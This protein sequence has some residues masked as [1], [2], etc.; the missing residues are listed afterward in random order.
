MAGGDVWWEQE[1]PSRRNTSPQDSPCL[2][3]VPKGRRRRRIGTRGSSR[4]GD[5]LG[6]ATAGV[7]CRKDG[8]RSPRS[9]VLTTASATPMMIS[10][11]GPRQPKRK[12][13]KLFPAPGQTAANKAA[14]HSCA[15]PAQGARL[16]AS[17]Q[18]VCQQANLLP[19]GEGAEGGRKKA[20]RNSL[21]ASIPA[22]RTCSVR[23]LTRA[24]GGG[25]LN[26]RAPVSACSPTRSLIVF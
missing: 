14:R 25:G 19:T 6:T 11:P 9:P 1:Q 16:C 18:C 13:G 20:S 26:F 10:F 22:G 3:A 4:A 23:F 21:S 7:V 17:L 15:L 2:A 8:P 12:I 5:P 24:G